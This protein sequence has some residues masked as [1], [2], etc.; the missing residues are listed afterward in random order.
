MFYTTTVKVVLEGSR[1]PLAG[2]DV[3][4]FDR[5]RFSSD[6]LLGSGTTDAAGEARFRY[7]AKDFQ[8]LDDSV[9]SL[10]GTFPDLYA[11]V[12]AP[13]GSNAV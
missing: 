11:V 1:Q 8:D 13:D 9:E 10:R 7:T 3:A 2:V 5:D 12:K 4:L 6:D